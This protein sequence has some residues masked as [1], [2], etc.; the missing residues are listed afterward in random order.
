MDLNP[1]KH[2][3]MEVF[4]KENTLLN[5]FLKSRSLKE[6]IRVVLCGGPQTVKKLPI[7]FI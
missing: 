6:G 4:D 1:G 3:R 5:L 2:W 7:N